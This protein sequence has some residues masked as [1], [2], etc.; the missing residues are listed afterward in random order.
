[1]LYAL[2]HLIE[3]GENYDEVIAIGP[4]PMMKFVSLLTKEYGIKTVVREKDNK[5]IP[6]SRNGNTVSFE[7]QAD[8][9]YI[10]I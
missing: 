4:L 9:T 8:E 1:M 5:E 3:A 2:R 7:T 6:F 10:L